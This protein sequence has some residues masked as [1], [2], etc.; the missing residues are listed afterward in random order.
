MTNQ[1]ARLTE[2]QY[3]IPVKDGDFDATLLKV[4]VEE[5]EKPVVLNHGLSRTPIKVT[6]SYSDVPMTSPQI[7][8]LN[9][10]RAEL[11]FFENKAT[12]IMRFE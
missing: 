5:A 8:T 11:Q 7:D 12:V 1:I 6:V 3:D 2:L 10:E 4:F 9:D